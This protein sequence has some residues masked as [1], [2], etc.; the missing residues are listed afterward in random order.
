MSK[1]PVVVCQDENGKWMG[2]SLPL[3][4]QEA[5]GTDDAGVAICETRKEAIAAL[6]PNSR[7]VTE[8]EFYEKWV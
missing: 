7:V 5:Y 6:P 2:F 1:K 3:P 8:K 4:A